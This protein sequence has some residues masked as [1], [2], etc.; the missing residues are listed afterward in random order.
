MSSDEELGEIYAQTGR[1]R[2]SEIERFFAN[3]SLRC[4]APELDLVRVASACASD[5]IAEVEQWVGKSQLAGITDQQARQWQEQ[6]AEF[7]AVVAAPWILI[8]LCQDQ[9]KGAADSPH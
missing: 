5:E 6:D 2:W 9:Q 1:V 4:V 7:W 8:Q 3:G